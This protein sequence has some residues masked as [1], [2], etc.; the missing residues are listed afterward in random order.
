MNYYIENPTTGRLIRVGGPTFELLKGTDVMLDISTLVIKED[1][2]KPTK[3]WRT[4]SPKRGV[5]RQLM[6]AQCGDQ[7]FLDPLNL[8]FPICNKD[9]CE[10]DCRGVL[11]AKVRASQFGY[12]DIR[13]KAEKIQREKCR[14]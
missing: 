1:P 4:A 12:E 8:K 9:T 6:R 10:I 7:C 11:S 5:E 14:K 3:G 13:K 2:I